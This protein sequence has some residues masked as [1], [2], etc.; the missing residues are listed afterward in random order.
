MCRLDVLGIEDKP[1]GDQ[2]IIYEEFKEPLTRDEEGWYSTGLLW[3][4]GHE[5]LKD[6]KEAS[7]G[8]LNNLTKRLK[9]DP[10]LF[11]EYDQ[12]IKDQ[13][14]EGIVEEAPKD[15]DGIE[16]YIPH[17][18]VVRETAESKFTTHQPNQTNKVLP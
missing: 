18:P 5:P 16:F 11:K 10:A 1:E 3:K 9:R 12:K 14:E 6:N 17:K 4:P 7:I 8:R 2:N 13:I 15:P